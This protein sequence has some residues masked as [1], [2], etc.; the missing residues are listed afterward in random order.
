MTQFF[1][2]TASKTRLAL[3]ITALSVAFGTAANADEFDRI[4]NRAQK[5][6]KKTRLLI[7]QTDNYRHTPQY[8]SLVDATNHL[9]DAATHVHQ[10]AHFANNLNHLQADLADLDQYFHQLESLFQATEDAASRGHGHVHK[11]GRTKG[12]LRSIEVNI[13][14]MRRDV[15]R[16]QSKIAPRDHDVH[17]VPVREAHYSAYDFHD[18]HGHNNSRRH[19][20]STVQP[21]P[22]TPVIVRPAVPQYRPAYPQQSCASDFNISIGGGRLNFNF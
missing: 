1:S 15:R 19:G 2:T 20:Q 8:P 4:D 5:I 10:V 3:I 9:Y 22:V 11:T 16:V 14:L 7:E 18:V 21:Q 13:D 12:L 6:Q 17:R